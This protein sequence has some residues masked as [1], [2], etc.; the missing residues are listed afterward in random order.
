MVGVDWQQFHTFLLQRM[1]AKTAGDRLRYAK[2]FY[3]ILHNGN[4]QGLVQLAQNKR[5]HTMKALASLSRFLGCR[6][7]VASV[8][9]L[10]VQ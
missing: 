2:Q 1:T 5:I 10:K 7:L 6:Q 4:A 9:V 3:M 8:L